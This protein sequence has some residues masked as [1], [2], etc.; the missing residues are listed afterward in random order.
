MLLVCSLLDPLGLVS[1]ERRSSFYRPPRPRERA[2]AELFPPGCAT[3]SQRAKILGIVD[4]HVKR[5]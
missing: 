5:E 2:R 4:C 1:T 3:E